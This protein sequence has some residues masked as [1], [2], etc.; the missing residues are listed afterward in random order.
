[1]RLAAPQPSRPLDRAYDAA[2]NPLG[3]LLALAGVSGA[4]TVTWLAAPDVTAP[5]ADPAD[6]PIPSVGTALGIH[7]DDGRHCRRFAS[8]TARGRPRRGLPSALRLDRRDLVMV[9]PP[10]G[11]SD[12]DLATLIGRPIAVVRARIQFELYGAP[13]V[14]QSWRDT[15]ATQDAGLTPRIPIGSAAS[16]CST[17]A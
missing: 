8:G 13:A 10:G 3:E 16:S 7:F 17:T 9:D 12:H 15:L 5:I 1:L 11:Q 4:E 14:N 2:G 6:I